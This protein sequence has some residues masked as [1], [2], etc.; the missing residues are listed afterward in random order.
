MSAEAS[1]SLR[2]DVVSPSRQRNTATTSIP[3]L[4]VTTNKSSETSRHF[5]RNAVLPNASNGFLNRVKRT[6][7]IHP[8]VQGSPQPSPIVG[9]FQK[10][11]NMAISLL[12]ITFNS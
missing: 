1:M 8:T 11:L 10:S 4:G 5:G 6:S 12:I 3:P 2:R 7:R 9:T